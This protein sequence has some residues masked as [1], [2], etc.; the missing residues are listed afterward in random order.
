MITLYQTIISSTGQQGASKEVN[1]V[2]LA[3]RRGPADCK[4]IRV[5]VNQ[6]YVNWCVAGIV[7]GDCNVE[8]GRYVT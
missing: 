2:A 3:Q 5:F 8:E 1:T 4:H 7:L 6:Y